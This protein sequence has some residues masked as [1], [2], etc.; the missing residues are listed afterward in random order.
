MLNILRM[1]LLEKLGH[2]FPCVAP[3][4]IQI[5]ARVRRELDVSLEKQ[6]SSFVKCGFCIFS[7]LLTTQRL[8]FL[9]IQIQ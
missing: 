9:S 2:I 3:C 8:C 7:D 4:F 5:D 6:L 1:T